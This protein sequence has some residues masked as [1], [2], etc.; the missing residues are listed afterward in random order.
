MRSSALLLCSGAGCGRTEG[1]CIIIHYYKVLSSEVLTHVFTALV[2]VYH[3]TR[4]VEAAV[5]LA[6]RLAGGG[7]WSWKRLCVTFFGDE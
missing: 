6:S 4:L 2:L 7:G 1:A 3:V 5:V